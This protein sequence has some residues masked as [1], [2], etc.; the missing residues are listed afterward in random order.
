MK[1]NNIDKFGL[2]ITDWLFGKKKKTSR[3]RKL[4]DEIGNSYKFIRKCQ[5]DDYTHCLIW[6][7][8]Y[9]LNIIYK[10]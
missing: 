4:I 3:L 7:N 8:I 5:L 6:Y 1:K 9:Y 10:S 2:A